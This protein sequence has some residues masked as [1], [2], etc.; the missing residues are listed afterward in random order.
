M[1]VEEHRRWIVV[2][3]HIFKRCRANSAVAQLDWSDF[4]RREAYGI[5]RIIHFLDI[6]CVKLIVFIIAESPYT[7][8]DEGDN[9]L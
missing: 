4:S 5:F 6:F 8:V 2:E 7:L 3:T 1:I 9:A